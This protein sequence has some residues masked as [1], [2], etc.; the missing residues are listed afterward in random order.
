M[1]ASPA[2]L[3]KIKNYTPKGEIGMGGVAAG[4]AFQQHSEIE[5]MQ[6]Y[7]ASWAAGVRY[8]DTSP[9]YGITKS[10]R[11]LGVFLD[12]KDRDSY[13]LSSK[14]GR[15]VIPD[16]KSTIEGKQRV[17][18]GTHHYKFHYDYSAEGVR[19]SIEDSLKRMGQS[20]FDIVYIH[21]LSPDNGDLGA[22]W[23]K[24]FKTAAKGAMPELTKM[25]EEGI[26]KAWGLGVNTIEPLMKTLEV[27]DP[28]VFLSACQYSLIKHEESLNRLF[29][30]VAKRN[31][32]VVVGGPLNVGFLAGKD[33]YDYGP[34]IPEEALKKREKLYEVCHK[35]DVDLRT[36][37]LQFS[38]APKEVSTILVGSHTAKQ[39]FENVASLYEDIPVEFWEELRVKGLI[40]EA[41]P[42]PA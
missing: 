37:A 4:G 17:W 11:R 25:R 31:I 19:R 9:W 14:I 27:A 24:Y 12:G 1:E 40:A 22:D 7:E 41:A 39:A 33:R 29:P 10:E 13:T 6:A 38:S 36:A 5:V 16:P 30:A 34:D 2:L 42:L 20:H 3:D 15:I 26:I 28:D 18:P 32:P 8:Y 21:D 35:F 23:E